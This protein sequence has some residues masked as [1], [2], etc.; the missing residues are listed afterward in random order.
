VTPEGVVEPA[1][2]TVTDGYVTAIAAGDGADDGEAELLPGWTVPGF[3]D[4]HVHG[5]GGADYA[6]TDPAETLRARRF[7]LAHGTTSSLAS[8]V[9][10]DLD[11]LLAQISTLVPL[12]ESGDFTGLHLEGPFLSAA[13]AGAHEP[14]LLRDPEPEVLDRLLEAGRG[15]IA[16]VTLAPERPGAIAA[17]ERLV[18]AGVVV[19]VGHTDGDA[20]VVRRALDAGATAATHLFN[21]MRPLHHRE[22]GPVPL[23]LTDPRV[24]VELI[25]DGFH[26]HPDVVAMAVAAA[27][28]DRVALVTDAMVAAG[29]PDGDYRLGHLQVRVARGQARLVGADGQPGSIAGSTLTMADA[30]AFVVAAGATVPEAAR[31]AATTP[32]RL[33]RVDSVGEIRVGSRADLCVVDDG[34]RLQRVLRRGKW[35]PEPGLTG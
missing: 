35:V 11:T 33:H 20:T 14:S 13:K 10:A 23:L 5:G 22:P 34:G 2:V 25:C 6:T 12:V 29:A 30:F 8:L 17:V 24:V 28:P 27:G 1:L 19:A 7:H 16:M 15:T 4:T 9:T 32:A 31:M 18:G 3:V 26:L 21:A